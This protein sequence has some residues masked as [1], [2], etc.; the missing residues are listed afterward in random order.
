[1]CG[2]YTI[3]NT[4]EEKSKMYV[5]MA[6]K[7]HNKVSE[8]ERVDMQWFATLQLHPTKCFNTRAIHDSRDRAL[9]CR[10]IQTHHGLHRKFGTPFI[11][12]VANNRIAIAAHDVAFIAAHVPGK[13]YLITALPKSNTVGAQLVYEKG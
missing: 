11:C 3:T 8:W 10:R 2:Q 4:M 9:A 12:R 1:M 5:N 13:L 6:W 7:I